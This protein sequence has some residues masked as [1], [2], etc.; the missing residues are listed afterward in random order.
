VLHVLQ[1]ICKIHDFSNRD[2]WTLSLFGNKLGI[3]NWRTGQC[4]NQWNSQ[5]HMTII[6]CFGAKYALIRYRG[7]KMLVLDLESC[8]TI[9]HQYG[10]Y[11]TIMPYKDTQVLAVGKFF[12]FTYVHACCMKSGKTQTI[13]KIPDEI[14]TSFGRQISEHLLLFLVA[15]PLKRQSLCKS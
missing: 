13:S 14:F 10:V 9:T 7:G 12:N 3:W 4:I 6:F 15:K 2:S 5:D 8:D 11:D 1:Q